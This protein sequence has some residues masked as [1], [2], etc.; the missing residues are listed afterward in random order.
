MSR[1]VSADLESTALECAEY[2]SWDRIRCQTV[3][4]AYSARKF[5]GFWTVVSP[6]LE[7]FSKLRSPILK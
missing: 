1:V 5:C 3:A 7:Y 2:E 4:E 6:S